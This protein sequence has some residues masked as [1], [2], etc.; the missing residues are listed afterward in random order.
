MATEAQAKGTDNKKSSSSKSGLLQTAEKDV[1]PV[2]LFLNKFNNDWVMNFSGIVAYNLLMSMLPIAIALLGILGL[3]LSPNVVNN[4]TGQIAKAIPSSGSQSSS[5]T[6]QALELA[7]TQLHKDAGII[8]AIAIILALFGGSR[9]F[10]TLEG[11]LDLLY[12]VRPRPVIRQNLVALGMLLL[13]IVLIPIMVFAAAAPSFVLSVLGNSPLKNIPVIDSIVSPGG[14][15]GVTIAGIVSGLIVSFVLFEAI[16][17]IVPNQRI[18]WRNSWRGAVVASILLNVFLV[19]FPFYVAHFLGGYAGQ[20]GF[21]VILLIFFYYFAVILLLG[22]EVNAYIYE[23]VQPLPNDLVTFV[24]TM[25]G[26]LNRDIPSSE[27]PAHTNIAPTEKADKAHVRDD[28]QEEEDI[29]KK[30]QQVQQQIASAASTKNS[31]KGNQT[32]KAEKEKKQQGPGTLITA[33]S[34]VAGTAL[35]F[36]FQVLQLRQRGK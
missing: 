24:S 1:K 28:L 36:V 34:V 26:K 13:F 6:Q 11:I 14:Q 30:N 16:Y 5:G 22:A 23:K 12:R 18:S 10:V 15:I 17:F 8:V 29:Q 25:G 35:A 33:L 3:F 21:A 4:I 27:S 20:I 7:L 9:L 2:Q 31:Q 32:K 19:A